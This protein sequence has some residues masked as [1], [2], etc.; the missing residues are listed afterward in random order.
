MLG[1]AMR[2]AL[3]AAVG[4]VALVCGGS[5]ALAQGAAGVARPH[6][7]SAASAGTRTVELITG[8]RVQLRDDH[9]RV[10]GRLLAANRHG[11]AGGIRI[12][13]VGGH[14][15]AIPAAALPYVGTSIDRSAFDVDALAAAERGG[16]LPL[17]VT[18]G[19]AKHPAVPG[20]TVTGGSGRTATGYLTTDSARAF[21]KALVAQWRAGTDVL[22]GGISNIGLDAP[23]APSKPVAR[24]DYPQVT[25]IIK[26]LDQNGKPVQDGF[27]TLVNVDDVDRYNGDVPVVNGEA[28]ASVPLGNY[29]ALGDIEDY[30]ETTNVFTVYQPIVADY[31]VK[32]TGQTLTVDA[33][34]TVPLGIR[35]PRP[36]TISTLVTDW[37]RGDAK[38]GSTGSSWI[39]D[40]NFEMYVSPTP[41]P[42]IGQ[43]RW[44]TAWTLSGTP[45]HGLPYTYDATF[46]QADRVAADQTY[47]VQN[48]AVVD[49]R[50]YTDGPTRPALFTRGPSYSYPYFFFSEFLPATSPLHRI[51]YVSGP[52]GVGWYA[53]LLANP[54]EDDPF[55]GD[56]EDGTRLL[57]A[58]STYRADWLRG[59]IVP[60]ANAPAGAEPYIYCFTCRTATRLG[61]VLAPVTDSDPA[62]NGYVSAPEHG[63]VAHFRL[64]R[65]GKLIDNEYDSA[66]G[67][68]PVPKAASTYRVIDNVQRGASGFVGSTSSTIDVTF[69]SAAGAGTTPPPGWTCLSHGAC[70]VLP[71][72]QAH[73]P[74]PTDLT[75]H[76]P[77]GASV[78]AVHIDH[79]PGA[80]T[81]TIRT[82]GLQLSFDG[83]KTWRSAPLITLGH[84]QFRAVLVNPRTQAGHW[85]SL[86]VTAT[87]AAG[88]KLVETVANAYSVSSS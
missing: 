44:M 32:A 67:A 78:T 62:H 25:L 31:Q 80:A 28:R 66:G 2:R 59:P 10:T 19:S 16:R 55:D 8:D 50:Y 87:D 27:V 49:A 53:S 74:L 36:A 61:I 37:A 70:T 13:R 1:D 39:M 14:T 3:L 15:Y 58:G 41:A 51:E 46:E 22:F 5:S 33:R 82:A 52:P 24:P 45:A 20:L 26:M 81:S 76:L 11:V 18:Y 43:L 48:P 6:P 38:G 9:G 86:R 63:H 71:M 12:S 4:V 73:I 35:T 21:G 54:T 60:G 40:G 42:K 75:G 23:V 56:V 65:N 34:R 69:R 29:S 77:V 7:A 47:R 68:F 30:N 72:L 17:R 57:P 88:G 83:G 64:Y 79:A 84:G 85:A